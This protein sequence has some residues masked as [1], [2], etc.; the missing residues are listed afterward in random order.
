MAITLFSEIFTKVDT[1]LIDYVATSSS[2]LITLLVP[3]F[4]SMF[5]IWVTIWGYMAMMGK[6]EGLLQDSFFRMLRITFIIMLGLTSAQYNSVI[7]TFLQQTP[8]TIA[9]TLT[10]SSTS[11]LTGL[12][13]NSVTKTFDSGIDAWNRAAWN[14][15]G[16]MLIAIIILGFGG[17]LVILLA[18]LILI[19]KITITVLLAIGP[20]FI[21][22]TLFQTTQR[23]FDSWIGVLMNASFVLILSASLGSIFLTIA[24]NFASGK[25]DPTLADAFAFFILFSMLIFF[26]KQIPGIAAAL[27]GGFALS[28]QGAIRGLTDKIRGAG[29][30]IDRAPRHFRHAK[31]ALEKGN[32]LS[33]KAANVPVKAAARAYQRTFR[34][35]TISN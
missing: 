5:I 2:N 8:E 14:D 15:I 24:D 4:N 25:I 3:I 22:S 33:T 12:L 21:I 9:A 10:G 35:N 6:V 31:F 19:S 23:F 18:S 11:S 29:N 20:L 32:R 1:A 26:V 13:D 28:A 16:Q 17:V 30:A 27:G 7:V 34:K